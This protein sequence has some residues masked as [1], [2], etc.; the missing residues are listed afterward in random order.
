MTIIQD[1]RHRVVLLK[2]QIRE[3]ADGS[4]TESWTAGDAVWARILP[5]LGREMQGEGWNALTAEAQ[6]KYKVTM[7]FRRNA[8]HRLQWEDTILALLC[9]PIIDGCR[10]WMTCLTY[11]VRRGKNE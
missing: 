7:R 10:R 8:F 5:C 9:P 2:R 6:I 3:E 11:E 4:F 1:L